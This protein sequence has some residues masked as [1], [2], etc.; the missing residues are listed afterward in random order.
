LGETNH[1]CRSPRP[2]PFTP[3]NQF[4]SIECEE[5]SWAFHFPAS[6]KGF[7]QPK[8]LLSVAAFENGSRW[9]LAGKASV[10]CV[11]EELWGWAVFRT[12]NLPSMSKGKAG[13]VVVV[14]HNQPIL[15]P[16][17]PPLSLMATPFAALL[18]N[19][20]PLYRSP[21]PSFGFVK[22]LRCYI[23]LV[24]ART[25]T[26]WVLLRSQKKRR[27]AIKEENRATANGPNEFY[28]WTP[29]TAPMIL[30]PSPYF[31]NTAINTDGD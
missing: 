3:P 10:I 28:H 20:F 29:F 9:E 22:P 2:P 14:K 12:L 15:S 5:N 7:A 25:P 6:I 16:M 13:L 19:I 24:A 4:L 17:C 30:S 31:T 21:S 8:V 27:R 23:S 26:K 18:S 1:C 11:C